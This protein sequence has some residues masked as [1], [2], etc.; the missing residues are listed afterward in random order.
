MLPCT[1]GDWGGHNSPTCQSVSQG[2]V[3]CHKMHKFTVNISIF[4][5]RYKNY[6]LITNEF[7]EF[8]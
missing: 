8:Y 1:H 5:S 3:G 6:V 7:H 4:H 2:D